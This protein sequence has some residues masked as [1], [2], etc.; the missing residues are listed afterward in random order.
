MKVVKKRPSRWSAAWSIISA[1][2]VAPEF[3]RR[4]IEHG[5]SYPE[6]F[7]AAA[8]SLSY[9]RSPEFWDN[10]YAHLRYSKAVRRF[11]EY[12]LETQRPLKR[13][14]LLRIRRNMERLDEN[15]R[16]DPCLIAYSG[17]VGIWARTIELPQYAR[18]LRVRLKNGNLWGSWT[19]IPI[20]EG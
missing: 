12:L 11:L 19:G 7:V 15:V 13:S 6:S 17:A 18:E 4:V 1:D 10:L 9:E 16:E 14:W 5:G 20:I 2:S 8:I 3:A